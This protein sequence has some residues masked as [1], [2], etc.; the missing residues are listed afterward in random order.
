ME[1]QAITLTIKGSQ[2]ENGE[3]STVEMFTEGQLK[4][5]GTSTIIEY[6]ESELSGLEHTKTRLKIQD[7]S[8]HLLRQGNYETEFIFSE[9]KT[10]EALYDTPAG[11]MQV[12]VFPSRVKCAQTS[13][14]GSLDLEYDIKIGSLCAHN[15]LNIV[16]E[17]KNK[18][19][20]RT[21]C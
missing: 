3:E 21:V 9:A 16:Y 8:I 1:K 15:R 2:I 17:H 18:N 10:F 7:D 5:D 13:A 20:G 6:E 14:G 4:Q 19:G 12:S 11:V